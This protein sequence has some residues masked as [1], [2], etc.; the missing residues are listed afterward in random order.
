VFLAGVAA[1][2][3]GAGKLRLATVA[4]PAPAL[5]VAVPEARVFGLPETADGA[6]ADSAESVD[7]LSPLVAG[8]DAVLL[9]T[10]A[11]DSETT[12]SL[13]ARLVPALD[14]G[15]V[16]V[17]AGALPVLAGQPDLLAGLDGRAVVMPN[18][19]EMATVLGRD[20]DAV[21]AD[22]RRALAD[23]V[24][25]LQAVVTL[26]GGETWTGAPDGGTFVDRSGSSG[27][28]TSGSG[29]VLAGLLAGLA[30]RGADPLTATLWAN[31]L[32][33]VAGDRCAATRGAL[34]FLARELLDE[35]PL[36]L[37]AL[38]GV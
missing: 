28:A 37:R 9:G 3:A 29:D 14:G 35:I 23:A 30:A 12:G 4:G 32:H 36:T 34:G 10:G 26:R 8:A 11:L 25:R 22:P 17:D 6:I 24:Q 13:L 21:I 31:H 2:R 27:L 5:A 18:P 15:V 19:M 38:C 1:L 7:V 16:V 20:V 33:G